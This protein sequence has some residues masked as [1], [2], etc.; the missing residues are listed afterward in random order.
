MK[1]GIVRVKQNALLTEPGPHQLS[2]KTCLLE[3]QTVSPLVAHVWIS[4][5]S[6]A[7]LGLQPRLPTLKILDFAAIIT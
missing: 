2:R 4:S 7:L 1:I 6:S 5:A 3:P